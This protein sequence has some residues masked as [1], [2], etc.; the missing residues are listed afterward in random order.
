MEIGINTELNT[1]NTGYFVVMRADKSEIDPN[2]LVIDKRD[3]KLIDKDGNPIKDYPYMV[4]EIS[5]TKNRDDWFNIPDV[6]ISYNKLQEEVQ[7]GNYNEASDALKSF[8][9][10]V[11][12]SPDLLPKDGKIIYEKV[13]AEISD[14][15]KAMQTSSDVNFS[16]KDLSQYSL[17]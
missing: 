5:S 12:T 11:Y 10:I 17:Q 4:F 2:N 13:E 1:V 15:L 16:L 7:K 8:R 3:F 14:I 6:S 9:R